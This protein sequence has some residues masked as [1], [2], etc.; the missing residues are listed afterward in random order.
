MSRKMRRRRRRARA[1][2]AAAPV[3]PVA[4]T[5]VNWS[6]LR[7]VFGNLSHRGTKLFEHHVLAPVT[8]DAETPAKLI[9]ATERAIVEETKK[10]RPS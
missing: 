5:P 8:V 7:Q 4:E 3:A 9:D 10:Q 1:A 2:Q 6:R